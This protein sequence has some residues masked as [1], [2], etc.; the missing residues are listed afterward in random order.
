MSLQ[1]TVLISLLVD[2]LVPQKIQLSFGSDCRCAASAEDVRNSFDFNAFSAC[3]ISGKLNAG[4][5]C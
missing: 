3:P 5:F 2:V 1:I 4:N